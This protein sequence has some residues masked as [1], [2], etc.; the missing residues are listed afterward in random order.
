MALCNECA[1]LDDFALATLGTNTGLVIK[2]GGIPF[3]MVATCD[4]LGTIGALGTT[5]TNW[6][7]ALTDQD[8]FRAFRNC[9]ITGGLDLEG[10]DFVEVGSCNER[11]LVNR[12][13]DGTLTIQFN[14]DNAAGDI[15][16]FWQFYHGKSLYFAHGLCDDTTI[17]PFVKGN[18]RLASATTPDNEND[19]INYVIEISFKAI[20]NQYTPIGQNFLISDL[21]IPA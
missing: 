9:T 7:L 16:K 5:I 15:Y 13:I 11:V 21:A 6:N 4:Q 2:S 1:T 3:L 12:S 20:P 19:F 18:V 14:E 17:Y 10:S 8:N